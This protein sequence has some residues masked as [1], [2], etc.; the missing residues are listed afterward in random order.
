MALIR[1]INSLFPC[2]VCLV[3][4]DKLSDLSVT[5]PLRTTEAM[6]AV[7]EEANNAP[8]AAEKEAILKESGL[9]D[10]KV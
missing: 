10:V 2:P 3:P 1:G 9:R 8:N 7:Y 4:G 6:K 5:F